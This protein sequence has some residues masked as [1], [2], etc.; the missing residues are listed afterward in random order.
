MPADYEDHPPGR[1]DCPWV[2]EGC[3]DDD[4]CSD[5]PDERAPI[6]L[7]AASVPPALR[8]ACGRSAPLDETFAEVA[9]ELRDKPALTK[10]RIVAPNASCAAAIRDALEGDAKTRERLVTVTRPTRY[11]LFEVAAWSGVACP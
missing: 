10:L 7:E 6:R 3:P 2:A 9:R 8:A 11:V 4:G 1:S 5:L